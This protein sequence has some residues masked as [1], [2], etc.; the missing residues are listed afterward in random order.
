[1]PKTFEAQIDAW[2]TKS[3]KVLN[4]VTSTA[5]SNMLADIEIVPGINRGGSR[6]RGTIPRDIGAL[7][8]SLE[9]SLMGSTAITQSGEESHV[10]V[11]GQMKAG[12]TATF[13]WGGKDA[14]Y[15]KDVHYGANGVPGTFWIDVAAGKWQGYVTAAAAKARAGLA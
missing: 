4:A 8:R 7:A 15:A 6:V 14:P 2:V 11:A 3:E 12:D 10:L 5:V 13:I 1:V 9:S